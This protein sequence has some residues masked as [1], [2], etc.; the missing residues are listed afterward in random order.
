MGEVEID[1][2]LTGPGGGTQHTLRGHVGG[3]C[4]V[5]TGRSWATYL[6]QGPWLQY[7]DISRLRLNWAIWKEQDFGKFLG[8]SYLRVTHK[9]YRFWKARETIDHKSE[10]LLVT[11]C[12]LYKT[13]AR[14]RG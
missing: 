3:P 14:V 1:V 7:F 5:Q 2:L 6:Y 9:A 12:V 13:F 10:H 11:L 8:V 4:R